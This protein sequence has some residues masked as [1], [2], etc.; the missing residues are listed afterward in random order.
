MRDAVVAL[1]RVAE[2]PAGKL[3]VMREYLQAYALRSLHESEAFGHVAFVGGTALRFLYNLPRFS[4]DL[5]FSL[6]ERMG[7]D[8][9]AWMKKL[10]RD[11]ECGGFDV[12]VSWNDRKAV[13]VAWLRFGGL[14]KEVGLSALSEQKLSIKLEVDTRPP[15]GAVSAVTLIN[16]HLLF[17]VR[18]YEL[19]SLMAGKIH[20]LIA[21]AYPKG[22]D[23]YDLLWYGA[24]RPP[25]EPN[26]TLLQHALDQTEGQGRVDAGRWRESIARKLERLD[27]DALRRDVESFLERP[28][29]A[30]LLTKENWMAVL[31]AK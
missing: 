20:A 14:M 27:E 31:G 13:H 26:R 19:S 10:K 8:P 21:R 29:D 3:N 2:S 6:Y 24:R 18:H 22:R 25:V 23:W 9:V 7:Y 1:A 4:E 17:A 16:R 28:E 12:D 15:E 30:H 11:F 5:D